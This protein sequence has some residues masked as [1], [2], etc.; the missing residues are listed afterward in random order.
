MTEQI[1]IELSKLNINNGDIIF[2]KIPHFL[3]S[4]SVYNDVSEALRNIKDELGID[5]KVGFIVVNQDFDVQKID[6]GTIITVVSEEEKEIMLND[7]GRLK[8]ATDYHSYV[9]TKKD[10]PKNKIDFISKE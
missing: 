7:I 1:K 8:H 2:I 4:Q 6:S 5:K 9:L 3:N 10:R